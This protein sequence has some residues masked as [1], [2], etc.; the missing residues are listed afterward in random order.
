MTVNE[1]NKDPGD[2]YLRRFRGVEPPRELRARV[3]ETA[4]QEMR[5][6]PRD[7]WLLGAAALVLIL[8]TA[9]NVHLESRVE[10]LAGGGTVREARPAQGEHREPELV[11]PFRSRLQWRLVVR[12]QPKVGEQSWLKLRAEMEGIEGSS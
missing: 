9:V 4:L 11:E 6:R 5:S 1:Q 2:Q 12:R 7:R 8:L 10:A 3:L